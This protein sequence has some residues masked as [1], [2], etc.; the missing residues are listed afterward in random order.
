MVNLMIDISSHKQSERDARRLAAIVESSDDAILAKDL[1]G[2]IMSWNAGAERLFGFTEDEAIGRPVTI[3]LPEERLDE[4]PEILRR[5]RRGERV[6]HFET[7]RRRKDGSLI[8]ISLTVSPVQDGEGRIIGAAKIAR[9]HNERR[10]GQ[11][12]PHPTEWEKP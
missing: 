12:D 5:I 8:D 7:V 1:D 4:E 2:T 10:R 9:S 6:E 3:L 11:E